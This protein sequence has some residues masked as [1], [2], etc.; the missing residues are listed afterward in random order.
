MVEYISQVV[1]YAK[2]LVGEKKNSYE[3]D[4]DILN[5]IKS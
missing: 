4:E 5:F 3:K 1:D 2:E